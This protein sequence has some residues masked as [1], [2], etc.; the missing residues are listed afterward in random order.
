MATSTKTTN[1]HT[2]PSGLT[3]VRGRAHAL[4]GWQRPEWK[5]RASANEGAGH[6]NHTTVTQ[7]DAA[8]AVSL[9]TLGSKDRQG[10]FLSEKE[11][12]QKG[13]TISPGE[14]GEERWEPTATFPRLSFKKRE[15]VSGELG[16]VGQL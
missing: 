1:S 16:S 9:H 4:D 2:Q 8:E 13:Q 11:K 5:P 7:W 3:S 10:T 15:M 12:V 6:T 14:N